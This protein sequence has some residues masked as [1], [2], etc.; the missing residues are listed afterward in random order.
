MR[1]TQSFL[2]YVTYQKYIIDNSILR[3]NETI[4]VMDA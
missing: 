4:K 3:N 1:L 2:A